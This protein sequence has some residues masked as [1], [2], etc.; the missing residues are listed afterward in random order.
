MVRD[1]DENHVLPG[2]TDSCECHVDAINLQPFSLWEKQKSKQRPVIASHRS[3]SEGLVL[4]D[5]ASQARLALKEI[6]R[7]RYHGD[8]ERQT[9]SL[10][11]SAQQLAAKPSTRRLPWSTMYQCTSVPFHPLFCLMGTA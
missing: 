6:R 10:F 11:P 7:R 9:A 3:R 1:R 4:L 5:S 2:V 8:T